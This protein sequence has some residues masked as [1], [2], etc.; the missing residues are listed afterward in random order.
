MVLPTVVRVTELGIRS[1]PDEYSQAAA[2]LGL[3]ET[4]TLL[5]IRLPASI[6]A[7]AAGV[8]LGMARAAAETAALIFTAGYV[9]RTPTS[10]L[11]SGRALSVHIY[12]LAMNVAGGDSRAFATAA[13]L[14]LILI[15]IN[16]ISSMFLAIF[17]R[18]NARFDRGQP[19][20]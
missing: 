16:S 20:P 6:N 7:L 10:L 8:A 11:D 4:T 18:H 3:S 1:V 13:T 9:T 12:D 15:G 17:H 19:I 2:A 5:H 14:V